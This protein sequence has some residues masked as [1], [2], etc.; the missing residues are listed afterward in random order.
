MENSVVDIT[1]SELFSAAFLAPWNDFLDQKYTT[2]VFDGGRGSCKSS[3]VALFIILGLERDALEAEEHRLAGDLN[4]EYYLTHCVAFRKVFG[5]CQTSVYSQFIWAIGKLGLEAEYECK[6]SPLQIVKKKTGQT[7][8]F[9][10]LD[11]PL[12][13]KSL[14]MPKSWFKYL[15]FEELSEYDGIDEIRSVRQS[16]LRGGIN[17]QV[18]YSYNPPQTR[19]NWVNYYME[20]DA[21]EDM[22][23]KRYHSDY[24]SVSPTWL[25]RQFFIEAELM[26]R[27]DLRSYQHQY[28]G[29]V[30]GTG[31]VIFPNVVPVRIYDE[32]IAQ[33]AHVHWG[34]DFGAIDPTVLLGVEYDKVNRRLIIFSEVYK[35][36]MLL[37]A[38]EREF[39]A[40]Y[41]GHEFIIADSAAP[42]M[43]M[44][45]Q[46]RG[47]NMLGAKKGPDSVLHGIK[48]IQNLAQVCIDP[49][50]CPNAYREFTH[51]EYK[52]LKTGQ[53][54]EQF[55][56]ADNH[57]IDACLRG[58]TSIW[59][60][61]GKRRID[62]LVGSSGR[63]LSYDMSRDCIA[64]ADFKNVRMTRRNAETVRVSLGN[65]KGIADCTPDHRILTLNGYVEA[66][67]LQTRDKVI[68]DNGACPVVGVESNGERHDVYDLEVP[69]YHNFLVNDGIVVHNCRY[70]IEDISS[71][72]GL[73]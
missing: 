49:F 4:W 9:R 37:D 65:G 18:F 50:R 72:A 2:M 34:V 31:G 12:K 73:F 36:A 14:K 11:D 55:P 6:K 54:A 40:H 68:C 5:T 23:L 21:H 48:F 32:D 51:Y 52:K 61:G 43:I 71:G 60:L 45:L 24:R 42:Q 3:A 29:E 63:L 67:S 58:D 16:V 41:F 56:D 62:S 39:K 35:S 30:T 22:T 15:W 28:L 8:L 64:A 17:Y 46:G 33:F 66:G 7:I 47:F 69:K 57:T 1:E 44:E 26:R 13:A 19:A 38:I 10:G 70:A 53:F 27:S 59:T 20:T 25:S